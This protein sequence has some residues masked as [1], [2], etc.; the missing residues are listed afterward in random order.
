MVVGSY[1]GMCDRGIEA[2]RREDDVI[3]EFPE[4]V[5]QSSKLQHVLNMCRAKSE[6]CQYL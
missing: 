5:A 1:G 6:M 2:S 3:V 4:L